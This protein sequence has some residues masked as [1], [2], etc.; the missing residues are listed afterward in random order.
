M[1][2]KLWKAKRFNSSWSRGGNRKNKVANT[3]LCL[4]CIIVNLPCYSTQLTHRERQGRGSQV[5][6][7]SYSF[8][9]AVDNVVCGNS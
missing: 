3:Q 7:Y 4:E 6:F 8:S 9:F 1:N 5:C 2:R